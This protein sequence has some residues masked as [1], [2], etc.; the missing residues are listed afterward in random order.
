V[1]LTVLGAS[2]LIGL[3]DPDD[4]R[5]QAARAALEAHADDDLRIAAHMLA[6]ALVHP[7]R[8]GKDR[9][10]WRLIDALEIS[11]DPV[12]EQVAFAAARLRARH[13]RALRMPDA[14]VLA[15]A[16]LLKAK[17]SPHRRR[18]VASVEPAR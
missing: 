8:A 1:A 18:A 15:H 6:E 3:L 17:T 11:V 2:V 9:E 12:D 16:D 14:L 13:G 5:H 7:A 10:A 4:A